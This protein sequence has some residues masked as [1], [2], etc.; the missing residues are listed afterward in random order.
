MANRKSQVKNR[1]WLDTHIHVSNISPAGELRENL[2]EDLVAVLDHCDAPDL[3]FLMSCDGPWPSRMN[4]SAE[5]ILEGNRFIYDLTQGAPGRLLGSCTVNPHFLDESLAMVEQSISEW[6]FVQVGEMLQY[7]MNYEMDSEPVEKIV[8][9]AVALDVPV[10][11]HISTSNRGEH[12]SSWGMEQLVDFFGIVD[13]VPEAKYV[14]AHLVGM[15]DD[16]PPVVDAYLDAVDERYGSWPDTFWA[17]IRDFNSPGVRSILGRVP[18]TRIMAGTDWCS[19]IGPPFQ[20]YGMIFG[21]ESPEQNPFPCSVAA[22]KGF[23]TQAGASDDVVRRIGF[24]NARE[25][26]RV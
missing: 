22:M 19:R 24:E 5:A 14:L 9:R 8:R 18:A 6:G 25:L 17:E 20:P 23:L 7:T 12:P 26:Y 2:L 16:D 4:E 3:R 10:Q 15:Q 1:K 13:R 11:V 21:V